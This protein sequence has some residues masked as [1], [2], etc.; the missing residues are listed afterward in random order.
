MSFGVDDIDG[1]IDDSTKIYSMAGAEEQTPVLNTKQLVKLIEQAG[2][3]PVERGT[4]YN[5]IRNYS[6][7]PI[8]EGEETA[9]LNS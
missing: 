6:E 5:E 7:Q 3:T 2:R 1:T 4:L 9:T 8:V